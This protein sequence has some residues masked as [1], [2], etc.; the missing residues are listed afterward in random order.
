LRSPGN[1][2]EQPAFADPY[3]E[4]PISAY[5]ALTGIDHPSKSAL[6]RPKRRAGSGTWSGTD[7]ICNPKH[8]MKSSSYDLLMAEEWDSNPPWACVHGGFQDRC[9]KPL[10]HPSKSLIFEAK[11]ETTHALK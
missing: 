1:G 6:V 5:L 8:D 4:F 7:E 3:L 2:E 10:G 11:S 9:L